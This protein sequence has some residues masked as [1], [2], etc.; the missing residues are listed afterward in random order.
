MPGAKPHHDY[1]HKA[2]CVTYLGLRR[3][4]LPNNL[5]SLGLPIG[6]LRELFEKEDIVRKFEGGNPALQGIADSA[7]STLVR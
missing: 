5:A 2:V 4:G 6:V 1:D 7:L 3:E